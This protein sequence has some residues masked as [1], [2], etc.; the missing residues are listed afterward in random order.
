MSFKKIAFELN[1]EQLRA[2]NELGSKLLETPEI[3]E[4]QKKYNCP[5]SVIIENASRFKRWLN[6]IQRTKKITLNDLEHD[7]MQGEYIDLVYDSNLNI[8]SEV[9]KTLPILDEMQNKKMYLNRYRIIPISEN[10][11]GATF[12][13]IQLKLENESKNY[14]NI[15]KKLFTFTRKSDNLGYYLY[16]DIGVGKTFLSACV[17]NEYAR[18]GKSV[19]LLHVPSFIS[20]LKD[21]FNNGSVEAILRS[22]RYTEVLVLDD[23]GAEPITPWSR[24]EILLAILNDRLENKR[25]TIITSNYPPELLLELYK[26][27][28]RGVSDTIRARRLVDRIT[29]LTEPCEISGKNRRNEQKR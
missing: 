23:L 11:E 14:Q 26:V 12:E 13:T 4:F 6:E 15:V 22:I 27:D 20:L 25:K 16:G 5:D 1:E 29:A 24:D 7:E 21:Q 10:L 9:I 28:S 3:K 8:L 2:R 19:A 17:T 18:R